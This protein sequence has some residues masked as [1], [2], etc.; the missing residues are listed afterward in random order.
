MI[1]ELIELHLVAIL[2]AC[3]LNLAFSKKGIE[4][5]IRSRRKFFLN[6]D[7]PTPEEIREQ[8]PFYKTYGEFL[9]VVSAIVYLIKLFQIIFKDR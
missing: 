8:Y 7:D 9:K 2:F 4:K 6:F 3:F 1:K 5:T